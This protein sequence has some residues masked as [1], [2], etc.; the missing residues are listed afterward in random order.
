MI[1]KISIENFKSIFNEEIE[2]GNLNLF[3]GVNG[4]GKSTFLQAMLIL[5]QSYL[6]GNLYRKPQSITLGDQDKLVSLGTFKDVLCQQA[7]KEAEK[8]RIKISFTNNELNYLSNNYSTENRNMNNV[9]GELSQDIFQFENENLFNDR[10]QYLAAERI[11]PDE[12]YPRFQNNELLGKRGEFTAHYIEKY[13]TKD[14]TINELS[15]KESPSSLTLINQI[16]DWMSEISNSIEV[17]TEENLKTNRIELSY[18][19]KMKDGTPTQNHKPQN[20]GFGITHTLPIVTAILSAKP[21]D[22]IIIENPETHLHP[23]GQSRLAH[24][25]AKAAQNNVQLFIE[26]HSDHIV[27]GLRVAVKKNLIDKEKVYLNYFS[28]TEQNLTKIEKIIVQ[29][30]GGLENWPDGFFDEWDNLLNELL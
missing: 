1:T 20:V 16:N 18:Q 15:L 2:V 8:I 7:I 13:G 6:S 21:Y 9:Y 10:C 27:N 26:T 4:S 11:Q 14:I 25:F 17:I 19:Y 23:R 22:I 12:D 3:T 24:L 5:R 30:G 29:K 28:K